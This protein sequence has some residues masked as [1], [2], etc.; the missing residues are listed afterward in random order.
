MRHP[1]STSGCGAGPEGVVA[2]VDV[3]GFVVVDSFGEAMPEDFQL[4]V[5]QSAQGT[6]VAFPGVDFAVV[7]FACPAG[8]GQ[9]MEG[10]LTHRRA[11]IAMM[12][13]ASGDDG[14]AATGSNDGRRGR[15]GSPV[16]LVYHREESF[17][18]HQARDIHS[19][20][21]SAR[22]GHGDPAGAPDVGHLL[23]GP[24]PP[25]DLLR[26]VADVPGLGAVGAD[27]SD[28]VRGGPRRRRPRWLR[29]PEVLRPL[30]E[31]TGVGMVDK[32]AS[33][34]AQPHR[35][36]RRMA[37]QGRPDRLPTPT[38]DVRTTVQRHL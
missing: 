24:L 32:A 2:V 7:E 23:P 15:E 13:Q 20:P 33:H 9:G 37:R 16:K 19:G 34:G 6:V 28:G 36:V 22:G 4:L 14:F 1:L 17:Y 18:G 5:R 11:E 30:R 29:R 31:E 8:H 38:R 35:A 26:A 21:H 3:T 27:R 12:S 25:G 10:P